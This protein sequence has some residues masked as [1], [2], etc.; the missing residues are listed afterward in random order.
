MTDAEN[1]WWT[2]AEEKNW[3]N[4][5]IK[6]NFSTI[7]NIFVRNVFLR[8]SNLIFEQILSESSD[9]TTCWCYL[10]LRVSVIRGA[11]PPGP[12]SVSEPVRLNIQHKKKQSGVKERFLF[13]LRPF[14]PAAIFS[15]GYF[16]FGLFFP[17]IS[18]SA[19]FPDTEFNV[20]RNN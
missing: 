17:A 3:K 7:A 11:T 12:P 15:L 4:N 19:I 2:K 16:F 18:S 1:G 20:F 5:N 6:I 9:L 13:I 8:L 10:Q 14:F